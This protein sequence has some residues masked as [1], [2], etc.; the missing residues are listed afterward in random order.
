MRKPGIF[1]Q[2][3]ILDVKENEGK[4]EQFELELQSKQ[5][6]EN[7]SFYWY[8]SKFSPSKKNEKDF[9]SIVGED[10]SELRKKEKQ[11]MEI[12]SSIPLGI[13]TVGSDKTIEP[14]YS[15]FTEYLFDRKDFEGKNFEEVIFSYTSPMGLQRKKKVLKI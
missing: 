8:I 4:D 2:K 15:Q 11:L 13:L 10:I 12:F 6:D 3:K 1:F 14:Q 7:K 5:D 9:Y